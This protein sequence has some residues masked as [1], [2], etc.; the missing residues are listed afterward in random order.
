MLPLVCSSSLEGGWQQGVAGMFR[1][2]VS[3]SIF[4]NAWSRLANSYM[5]LFQLR[6]NAD[7]SV[8]GSS[9]P[10]I[11]GLRGKGLRLPGVASK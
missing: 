4:K 6:G 8:G 11:P 2:K 9:L 1:F 5:A 10:S 3:G 7:W